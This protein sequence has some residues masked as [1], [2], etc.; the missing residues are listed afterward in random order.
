MGAYLGNRL[1][2]IAYGSINNKNSGV[3]LNGL[4]VIFSQWRKGMGSN[5]L[6]FFEERARKSGFRSVSLGC[7]EG[8]T[9]LFYLKNCY[10]PIEIQ[11]KA[12][13]GRI[14]ATEKVRGYSDGLSKRERLREKLRP[15]E[16]IFIFE[17][18]L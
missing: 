5:L 17:K 1:V 12:K 8:S 7:G 3:I 2:G 13:D 16:T 6:R 11:A 9:E 10:R 18:Q 14:L 15:M 4:A